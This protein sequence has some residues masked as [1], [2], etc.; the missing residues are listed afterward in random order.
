MLPITWNDVAPHLMDEGYELPPFTTSAAV[1]TADEDLMTAGDPSAAFHLASVT[2]LLT[3]WATLIAADRGHVGLDVPVQREGVPETVTLRHL[4]AHASGAPVEHGMPFQAPQWR[5]NY[6]N[7]GMEIVG[8]L[9]S[10]ATG[11]PFEQWVSDRLFT[12][13]GMSASALPGSPAHGGYSTI[14]D[15]GRFIREILNPTLIP[16][17]LATQAFTVQWPE[18]AGI[19][20]GYGRFAPCP[21]GMGFQVRGESEHWM[22]TNASTKTVGHFGRSGSFV[23]VDHERGVGAAFLGQQQFGEWHH[24][25]WGRL[26]RA[27]VRVFDRQR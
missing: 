12:P 9:V 16:E 25:N 14:S 10:Q 26:N 3:T 27:I 1:L 2:K 19:V 4:L 23:W 8:E 20:P 24:R 18:L 5:R 22:P 21:W 11:V 7:Y 17:E 13:L 6:S 15:L